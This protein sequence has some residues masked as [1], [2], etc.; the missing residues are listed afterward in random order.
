MVDPVQ[1]QRLHLP[2]PAPGTCILAR[3]TET[4]AGEVAV[5]DTDVANSK[6]KADLISPSLVKN[7]ISVR[8][9]TRDNNVI[10]EFDPFGFSIKDLPTRTVLLRCESRGELYP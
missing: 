3:T 7:L 2:C 10:I 8:T 4:T 9:L 6:P 5:V 1:R